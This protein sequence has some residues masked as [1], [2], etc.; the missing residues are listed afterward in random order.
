M[1]ARHAAAMNHCAGYSSRF[2]CYLAANEGSAMESSFIRAQIVV[3]RNATFPMKLVSV[4]LPR[5]LAAWAVVFR[6]VEQVFFDLMPHA[7]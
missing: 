1:S 2:A 6:H 7:G 5:A 4:Q 3:G